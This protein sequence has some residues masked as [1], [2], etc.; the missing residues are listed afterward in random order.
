MTKAR[1]K[2]YRPIAVI[3]IILK[4]FSRVLFARIGPHLGKHQ[5]H[6]QAGFR[7]DYGC[8]DHLFTMILLAEAALEWRL[9]LW[10]VAV[11]FRKAFDSVEHA[12]IWRALAKQDVPAIYIYRAFTTTLCRPTRSDWPEG[13]QSTLQDGER[14]EARR[15]YINAPF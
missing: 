4:L 3:S 11:D 14:D 10:V 13:G 8:D 12:A 15:S 6:D 7:K 2:N 1:W 9:D 5:S